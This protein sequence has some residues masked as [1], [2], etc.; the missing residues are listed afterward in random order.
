[1]FGM[2]KSFQGA[3]TCFTKGGKWYLINLNIR[4]KVGEGRIAEEGGPLFTQLYVNFYQNFR[5]FGEDQ[6]DS[7]RPKMQKKPYNLFAYRAFPNGEGGGVRLLGIVPSKTPFF[8]DCIP[9]DRTDQFKSFKSHPRMRWPMHKRGLG[10]ISRGV[11]GSAAWVSWVTPLPATTYIVSC[12]SSTSSP[13]SSVMMAPTLLIW[14]DVQIQF[15]LYLAFMAWH[16]YQ[17][18]F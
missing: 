14:V 16:R 1:M 15:N 8:S 7:L 4:E 9:M 13:L 5:F 6:K 10:A 12:P 17:S 11:G 18:F 2:P 3:E